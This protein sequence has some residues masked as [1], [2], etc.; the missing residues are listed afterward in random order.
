MINKIISSLNNSLFS[1]LFASNKLV[2]PKR[3]WIILLI[4]FL[5]MVIS[6]VAYD[7]VIYSKISSGE[8]YISI[9]RSELNLENLKTA[10]LKKLIENFETKSQ[11]AASLKIGPSIDPSI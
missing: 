6:V 3:D 7:S 11:K 1:K 9:N 10:E 8:M 4:T 5:V 2:S